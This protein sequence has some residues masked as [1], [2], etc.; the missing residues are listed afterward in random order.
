MGITAPIAGT[1]KS[2]LTNVIAKIVTDRVITSINVSDRHDEF[3]KA[4]AA[5]LSEAPPLLSLDNVKR[6][7]SGALL[8]QALSEP[9]V[10]ERRLGQ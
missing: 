5:K 3:R 6:P 8:A 2:Y 7:L 10:E 1:G 4:L 9:E